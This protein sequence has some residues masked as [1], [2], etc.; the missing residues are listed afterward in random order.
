MRAR[1]V[2]GY[3]VCGQLGAVNAVLGLWFTHMGFQLARANDPQQLLVGGFSGTSVGIIYTFDVQVG[4]LVE[5]FAP[6]AEEPVKALL[7]MRD[8]L[9]AL[10]P[11]KVLVFDLETRARRSVDSLQLG[12]SD[13]EAVFELVGLGNQFLIRAGD[14]VKRCVSAPVH[15]NRCGDVTF[16]D[17]GAPPG[18]P[19]LGRGSV[20]V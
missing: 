6:P 9:Y 15:L 16:G 4:Q 13:E 19:S 5:L 7:A 11:S 8:H 10:T 18:G 12:Q 20:G 2:R 14:T 3:S 17:Q 1:L